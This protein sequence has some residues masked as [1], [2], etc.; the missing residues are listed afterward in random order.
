MPRKSIQSKDR[1]PKRLDFLTEFMTLRHLDTQDIADK[2]NITRTSV[3]CWFRESTDDVRLS[4]AIR[5]IEDEGFLLQIQLFRE[6]KDLNEPFYTKVSDLSTENGDLRLRRLSFLPLTL[7]K[8]DIKIKDVTAK[9]GVNVSNW[10][11]WMKNDDIFLSR[12]Y[13]IADVCDLNIRFLITQKDLLENISGNRGRCL[14]EIHSTS[15]SDI[16]PLANVAN[17]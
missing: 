1:V 3:Y 9:M 16:A 4:Y 15:V 10:R 17:S 11:Y 14:T 5:I 2:L 12:I 7:R 13:Q 6:E 8:Y